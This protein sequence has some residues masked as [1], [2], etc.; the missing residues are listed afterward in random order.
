MIFSSRKVTSYLKFKIVRRVFSLAI[1]YFLV[2]SITFTAVIADAA[3]RKNKARRG[4]GPIETSLVVDGRTG[5]IL[6]ARNAKAKIYPASLTK[7][8]TL[9]LIFEALESGKLHLNQ[10]L[11]VSKYATQAQ[12]SKLYLRAKDKISV[13]DAILGLSVKSANDVARVV[14]ENMAGSEQK[15]ARLMTIRARQLGM[16][17]TTFTNASGWHDKRQVTTAVDLAKLSIAIKRDF[18]QY[19]HFFAKTSF[20]FRGKTIKGHNKVTE[21]YPGAEGLKTGFHTP[22]GCNLITSATRGNK[23]LVAV[24]TGS[25]S[26]SI[27]DKKMVLLL[28]KYFGTS[29]RTIKRRGRG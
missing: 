23:N 22:A 7:V 27:R 1:A 4:G 28:D 8:M 18:P 3:P 15:F 29:N 10:K 21:T 20:K 16:H 6:H 17:D 19:Y 12:P 9:Y 26:S 11:Y 5:K 14:A 13:R 2:V 25:R 24:V